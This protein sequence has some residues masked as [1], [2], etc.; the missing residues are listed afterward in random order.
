MVVTALYCLGITQAK[1]RLTTSEIAVIRARIRRCCQS[2]EARTTQ[3]GA[4]TIGT[5]SLADE[6]MIEGLIV[7]TSPG[8]CTTT[9]G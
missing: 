5:V 2:R 6:A 7:V 1:P 4:A 3:V 8:A 9:G